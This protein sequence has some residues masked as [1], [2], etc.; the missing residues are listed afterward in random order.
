MDFESALKLELISVSGLKDKVFPL[1]ASE[2]DVNNEP[3]K[4]PYV[5]YSS[6]DGL[7]EKSMDGYQ[8]L[9]QVDVTINVIA[10]SYPNLKP[11]ESAIITKLISFQSRVIGEGG[12]F[13][14]DITYEEPVELFEPLPKLHRAIIS[15]TVHFD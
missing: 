5:V 1:V 4:A 7:K 2:K 14:Q 6:S 15:F 9:K 8:G 13:I 3:L 10:S 11:L 12:P